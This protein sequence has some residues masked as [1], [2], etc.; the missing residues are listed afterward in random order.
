MTCV[1]IALTR[2]RE[3]IIDKDDVATISGHKWCAL[4]APNGRWYA[5]CR[6][7]GNFLFM[8][9]VIMNAPAGRD[10]DHANSDG[11]DNRRSNLRIATRSQNLGNR[12]K[13]PGRSSRYK[14][15]T[16]HKARHKWRAYIGAG[17]VLRHLGYFL[18]EADAALAYD[19]AALEAWGE[20]ARTNFLELRS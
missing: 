3:A 9:R 4:R 5:V 1:T 18:D 16:W 14:G 10:V 6:S 2:G 17:G 11:L 19:R 15:V 8:H 13:M 7:N 20:F 12:R